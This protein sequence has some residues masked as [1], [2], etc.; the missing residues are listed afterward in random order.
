MPIRT[1]QKQGGR[2]VAA[3]PA[4]PVLA[5]TRP[6]SAPEQQA[7]PAPQGESAARFGHDF[8]RVAVGGAAP[9]QAK[10]NRTGLP[11]RLKAGIERLS[12]VPL[13]DVKV[14]YDSARPAGVEAAAYTQGTEIHVAPGQHEHLAHEAW[15]VVQQKQGRVKPTIRVGGKPVND[16]AGL[17]READ[18]MGA[19]AL[20]GPA[21]PAPAA[22]PAPAAVPRVG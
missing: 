7:A 13:D 21:A 19:K 17:E 3:E 4:R 10:P 14:H 1:V 22:L 16:D 5:A 20:A 6:F 12:G 18:R 15:H 8:G 9:I 11:G 2:P